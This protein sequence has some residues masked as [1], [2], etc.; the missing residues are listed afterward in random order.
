MGNL[1]HGNL[2]RLMSFYSGLVNFDPNWEWGMHDRVFSALS[3]G[4]PVFTHAN[5]APAEEGLAGDR[6][7]AFAPNAPALA[8]PAHALLDAPPAREP[9]SS[10]DWGNRMQRLLAASPVKELVA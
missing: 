5:A 4:V 8:A 3:I 9:A 6:V 7:I 2:T 10:V 1:P